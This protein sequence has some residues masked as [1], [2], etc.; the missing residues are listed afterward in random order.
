ML[1]E[2]GFAPRAALGAKPQLF[3]RRS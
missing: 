1:L 2:P 3:V